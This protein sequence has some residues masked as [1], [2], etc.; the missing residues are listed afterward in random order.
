MLITFNDPLVSWR[1]AD[2]PH[3]V[4]V[5]GTNRNPSS[6]GFGPRCDLI[7]NSW[8]EKTGFTDSPIRW[9]RILN[10]ICG[11]IR[12]WTRMW[13]PWLALHDAELSETVLSSAPIS[14]YNWRT[15]WSRD[16]SH[17]RHIPCHWFL[18]MSWFLLLCTCRSW[19]M[20]VWCTTPTWLNACD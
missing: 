11:M 17:V 15:Y 16:S 10:K 12:T 20:I 6:R 3:G 19:C 9:T 18:F 8:W 14:M 7:E 1:S 5:N 13:T 2:R 4:A